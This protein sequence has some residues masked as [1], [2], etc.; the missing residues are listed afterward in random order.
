MRKAIKD[1]FEL[2]DETFFVPENYTSIGAA[3]A[4]FAVVED[5]A[6]KMTFAGLDKLNAYLHEERNE[7]THESFD[8]LSGKYEYRV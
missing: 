2:T 5:P 3:G 4:V 7:P 6:L 8:P 1:V